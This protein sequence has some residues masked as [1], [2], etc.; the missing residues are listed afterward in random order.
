VFDGFLEGHSETARRGEKGCVLS[1]EKRKEKR[2]KGGVLP[3]RKKKK[4]EKSGITPTLRM[5]GNALPIP[6]RETRR[7]KERMGKTLLRTNLDRR[8][9]TKMAALEGGKKK[10]GKRIKRRMGHL[11]SAFA[12][13]SRSQENMKGE[14]FLRNRAK[15]GGRGGKGSSWARRR[16]RRR[17][18][19]GSRKSEAGRPGEKKGAPLK[20][21]REG[22]GEGKGKIHLS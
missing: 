13:H 15:E 21:S 19:F 3:S 8:P 12:K 18:F 16:N 10:K 4:K 20:F 1:G 22:R 7:K 9:A 17:F 5:R 11:Q 2:E 14:I 6:F